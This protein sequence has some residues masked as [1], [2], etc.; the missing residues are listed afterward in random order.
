MDLIDTILDQLRQVFREELVSFHQS[1]PAQ[2]DRQPAELGKTIFNLDQ[3]CEYTGLSKQTAYKLTGKGLVPHSKRG[4]RLYFSKAEIDVW[5]LQNRV[6]SVSETE[7]K[8]DE[9]LMKN[10]RR[11]V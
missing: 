3:F 6:G 2:A 11:R 10:R 1:N 5:L 8:A 9:Y 7:S 4:K